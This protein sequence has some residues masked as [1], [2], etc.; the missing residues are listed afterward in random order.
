MGYEASIN[1][2]NSNNNNN[3]NTKATRATT[4]NS[5]QRDQSSLRIAIR[6][7]QA[8]V[9]GL[10][11]AGQAAPALNSEVLLMDP[12]GAKS[13]IRCWLVGCLFLSYPSFVCFFVCI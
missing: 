7:V 4:T 9:A 11:E 8:L 2:N 5:Q 1:N 12:K 13:P 10:A 6:K 3:N